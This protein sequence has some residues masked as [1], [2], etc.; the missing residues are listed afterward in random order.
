MSKVTAKL[1]KVLM[2]GFLSVAGAITTGCGDG[3]NHVDIDGI[4]NVIVNVEVYENGDFY[5][6]IVSGAQFHAN[7]TAETVVEGGEDAD[8][9]TEL[10]L[11]EVDQSLVLR[12]GTAAFTWELPQPIAEDDKLKSLNTSLTIGANDAT[13]GFVDIAGSYLS[14]DGKTFN[15]LVV[16]DLDNGGDGTVAALERSV[17]RANGFLN[18]PSA[19]AFRLETENDFSP[20]FEDISEGTGCGSAGCPNASVGV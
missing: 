4:E 15:A 13:P 16:F 11:V 10:K 8:D 7:I 19:L 20:F 14:E 1:S 6:G 3:A 9:T 12:N 18:S 17:K 2:L 5:P